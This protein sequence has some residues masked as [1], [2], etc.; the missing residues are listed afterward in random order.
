MSGNKINPLERKKPMD[1]SKKT[2]I[3]AKTVEPIAA[4]AVTAPTPKKRK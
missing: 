1:W 2:P 4:P 3:R